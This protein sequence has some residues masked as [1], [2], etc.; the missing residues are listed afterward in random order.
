MTTIEFDRLTA[1]SVE[2]APGWTVSVFLHGVAV[3]CA[4][5]FMAEIEQPIPRDLFQ[6]DVS[7]VEATA[8][9]EPAQPESPPMEKIVQPPPSPVKP[10]PP[11]RMTAHPIAHQ[12]PQPTEA[13]VDVER[14]QVVKDVAVNAEPM[15]EAMESRPV[16]AQVVMAE[17][18]QTSSESAIEQTAP[19]ES[20]GPTIEHRTVE[21]RQVQY[22]R[23]Q[24]DYGW[25][26][27]MLWKRIEELKRYP[28]LARTN[29][30]EGKVI[31]QAIIKADGTVGDVRVAESSGYALL[32]QEALVVMRKA[33]P[34]ALKYQLEKASITI[35]VPISY[36]LEG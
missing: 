28:T 22:R 20:P 24:A 5:L 13:P 18:V 35:L 17:P 16:M 32:D 30:W 21:Y 6:W 33:S 27:D 26:R 3:A 8:Q 1:G 2:Q 4:F 10:K 31:V 7:M 29:H 34:L 14:T 36:H 25:L 15:V 9:A 11:I 23:T 12:T 19:V